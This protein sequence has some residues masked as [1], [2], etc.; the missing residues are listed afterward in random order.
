MRLHL[1]TPTREKEI[2][3]NL[4]HSSAKLFH[5]TFISLYETGLI[6]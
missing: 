5:E 3:L 6:A 4:L 2:L 1:H